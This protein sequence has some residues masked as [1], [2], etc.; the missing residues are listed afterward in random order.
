MASAIVGDGSVGCKGGTWKL[1][2]VE[3]V[4]KVVVVSVVGLVLFPVMRNRFRWRLFVVV[5]SSGGCLGW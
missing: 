3:K 5:I 1:E 2:R 4:V